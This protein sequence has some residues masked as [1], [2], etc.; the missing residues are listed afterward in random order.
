MTPETSASMLQDTVPAGQSAT[1]TER[2]PLRDHELPV[3][4]V[5][6]GIEAL[7]GATLASAVNE[8]LPGV[9]H[10]TVQHE[11]I[12]VDVSSYYLVR[13]RVAIDPMLPA[14]GL[15]WFAERDAPTAILLTNRHH[16]RASGALVDAFGCTVHCHRAGLHEFSKGEPVEP[17]DF[18]AELPGGAVACK[19][20]AICPEE[21]ALHFPAHRAL[22]FADGLV[23]GA[24]GPLGFVP[25]FLLGDDPA[26]VKTGLLASFRRLLEFDADHLLFAH[27][28]PIVGGGT[29]AL[30]DFVETAG[31]SA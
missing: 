12:G 14:E 21:T 29:S 27:G 31:A 26:S 6:Q 11:R 22:A 8:I 4:A 28:N 18:G 16:Y 23:R 20:G 13:E 9:V 19:V 5:G 30:R 1:A 25:D 10:W 15:A 17:F 2:Q 7:S 24:D 3:G